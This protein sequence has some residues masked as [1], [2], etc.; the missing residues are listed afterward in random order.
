MII[1]TVED[2]KG[3]IQ[4]LEI[5]EDI[6]LNLME[7]LKTFQ[8]PMRATCGGMGLCADCH[9]RVIQGDNLLPEQLDQEIMTLEA[10]PESDYDSRLSCQIKVGR[11]ISGLSI[12]LLG[13]AE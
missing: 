12:K 11:A 1:V 3:R 8:Y 6:D 13:P 5:P 2:Q 10:V 7:T 4:Q 9:C